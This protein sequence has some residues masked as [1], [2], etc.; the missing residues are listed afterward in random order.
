MPL[1]LADSGG[2]QCQR[3]FGLS[4]AK[5]RTKLRTEFDDHPRSRPGASAWYPNNTIDLSEYIPYRH[6][7][8]T[9]TTPVFVAILSERMKSMNSLDF[10]R[11]SE[12][13][14]SDQGAV[15]DVYAMNVG[16][17][18]WQSLL[19]LVS[20]QGW[21][22]SYTEDGVTAILPVA[23]EIFDRKRRMSCHFEFGSAPTVTLATAFFN[24]GDVELWFRPWEV[25]SQEQLDALCAVLRTIGRTLQS[26]LLVTTVNHPEFEHFR[27]DLSRDEFVSPTSL[28]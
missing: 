10:T 25:G 9:R 13:M 20:D 23:E 26:D 5:L 12:R 21:D 16:I 18:G 17:E 15:V 24:P 14:L 19:G 27:Y 11:I 2:C 4:T 6:I 3:F 22:W 28:P 7:E 1:R 8:G